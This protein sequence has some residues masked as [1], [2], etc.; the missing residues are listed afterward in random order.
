VNVP[1][2]LGVGLALASAA[3]WGSGDFSGGLAA[4]R[5][6]QFRVLAQAALSGLGVLVLL[7]WISD[8]PMPT[9][10]NVW[11]ALSAGVSGAIGLAGLYRGLSD[12]PAASFAPV[13]A[14]VG[15]SV[16]VLAGALSVG[17]PAPTEVAG[18]S[19]A[20]AA[21]WLVSRVR[22]EPGLDASFE[23]N[24]NLG[25][26]VASGLAFGGFFILVAQ[27]DRE[28]VFGPL[29]V[30]RVGTLAV[31]VAAVGARGVGW[32]RPTEHPAALVAG[33]LDAGGTVLYLL[34]TR[35]TRMDVAAVL[36]SLYPAVT[37]LLALRFQ[38]ERVTRVQWVGLAVCLL[39]VALIA[40]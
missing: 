40:L 34:A 10:R 24:R 37:V 21:I 20:L 4:R 16:P 1:H 17:F 23:Q 11:W 8:E 30:A 36:G 29:A 39:A 26:A 9:M 19:A 38:G 14:V 25:L 31:A 15:A 35:F 18:V 27:I 12:N 2:L 32:P 22:R 33:V 3:A 5:T 28:V 13:V 7:A 6:D